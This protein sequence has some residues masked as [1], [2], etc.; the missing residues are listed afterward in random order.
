MMSTPNRRLRPGRVWSR[1]ARLGVACLGLVA[2]VAAGCSSASESS[3][4]QGKPVNA[5]DLVLVQAIRSLSNPYHAEWAKGGEMF[6]ASVGLPVQTLTDGG[7]SQQQLNQIKSVLSSGKTVV[8]NADPNTTSDTQAIVRAVQDA[9]G[10]VVTQWNKPDG[11]TPEQVGN[12]WVAHI[13]FDGNTGGYQ[14]AKALFAGMNN[15]GGII[16]LQ[17]ILDDV[18]AKERFAGLQK[19][20]AETPGVQLLDQQTAHWT[21][22]EA[23]QVTQTLLAKHAGQVRG[24]WAAN[25]DMA[26]GAIQALRAVGLV[27]KVPIVGASDAVPEALQDIQAGNTGYLATVSTD[28][29]WQGGAGLALAYAAATGKFD[30]A[31]APPASRSFYGKEFLV[32][33][34]NVADFLKTPTAADLAPDFA[35]PQARN[36]GPLQ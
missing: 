15:T 18:P 31:T 6:A 9:G 25:D 28:A 21:R 35:N 32:T 27:G 2:L 17:G 7:D 5:K 30:V 24:V 11:L 20:L 14:T 36:V 23:F 10:F 3:P 16:A 34:A 22:N 13:G 1:R 33:K 29:Y 8:L 12:S 4:N 26:L 19:A